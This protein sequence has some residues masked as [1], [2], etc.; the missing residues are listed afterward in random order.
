MSPTQVTGGTLL[1][2]KGKGFGENRVNQK[3]TVSFLDSS[4]QSTYTSTCPSLSSTSI[5]VVVTLST[6]SI[7]RYDVTNREYCAFLNSQGNLTENSYTWLKP[8]CPGITGTGPF[9]V[10]TGY[11]NWPVVEV[12]LYCCVAYCNWMS[13]QEGLAKCYGGY[14]VDGSARWGDNGANFSRTNKGYRLPTNAEWEYACR[15]GS[16][17]DYFWGENYDPSI[18]GSP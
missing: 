17:N 3:S 15:A 6:F 4:G 1:T 11:E 14:S 2:I 16:T 8:E 9:S 13:E 18:P 5:K 10:V 12:S 7:G